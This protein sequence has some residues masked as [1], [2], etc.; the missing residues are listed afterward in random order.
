MFQLVF[1]KVG[2]HWY[3]DI[4]HENPSDLKLDRRIEFLLTKAD[5]YNDKIVTVY[6]HELTDVI[7]EEG[8]IQFQESDFQRYFLTND[9]FQMKMW[10]NNRKFTISSSLY[11]LIENYYHLD[12]HLVAYR[13][14]LYGI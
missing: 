12:L 9:D 3:L 2:N 8:L 14:S 13:I 6:L 4:P 11:T 5:K 7:I 1:K 10:I